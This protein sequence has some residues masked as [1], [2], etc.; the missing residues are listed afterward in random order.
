MTKDIWEGMLESVASWGPFRAHRWAGWPGH[1]SLAGLTAFAVVS[2][3]RVGVEVSGCQVSMSVVSLSFGPSH[4]NLARVS[5][6]LSW[7]CARSCT[8]SNSFVS[9]A[10]L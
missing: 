1:R 9:S 4:T 6:T 7:R 10:L 8:F 2:R 3:Y 5:N